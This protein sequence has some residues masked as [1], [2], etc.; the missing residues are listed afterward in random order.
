MVYF[1]DILL[2]SMNEEQHFEHLRQVLQ[3]LR[4]QKL[5]A[6]LKKCDFLSESVVFLGYVVSREGIKVDPS[7]VDAILNWP[8]PTSIHEVRSFH[9][10][11]SFYRRFVRNFSS[12]I[13]HITDC[14]K[15][16]EFKWTKEADESFQL[17]KEKMTNAS[18]LALPDF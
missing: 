12:I 18:V 7:K 2:Y 3:V 4:D 16:G 1:D 9:G 11:A 5:Y 15:C 14:L 13:T 6:N 10:L 8:A 17:V